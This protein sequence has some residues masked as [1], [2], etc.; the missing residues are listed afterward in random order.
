MDDEVD[1]Y[2]I[3]W[4]YFAKL[5]EYELDKIKEHSPELADEIYNFQLRINPI[6]KEYHSTSITLCGKRF[7]MGDRIQRVLDH[8]VTSAKAKWDF[9]MVVSG[10][11]GAA[12]STIARVLGYYLTKTFSHKNKFSN[13]N[14]V[15]S[16]A[17][18][19][20]AVDELPIGST[21][22]WD[23]FVLAGM[24]TDMGGVQNAII[25]KF[26][27]IR[28]KQLFI[29]LVIPYIWM[30]RT[31]FAIA[32]TK[33][34]LDVYTPDFIKRG[35]YRIWG[36]NK[37]KKLY[38]KGSMA[39]SKWE[40]A[41]RSSF[42]G[43]FLKDIAQPNFF[44]DDEEYEKKKDEAIK[45]IS[46]TGKEK[47]EEDIDKLGGTRSLKVCSACHTQSIRFY[48]KE[49]M[50]KCIACGHEEPIQ[51]DTKISGG[52]KGKYGKVTPV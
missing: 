51:G 43:T 2:N 35:Y 47:K 37:K 24:S 14:I 46:T 28:K 31:Y 22:I 13:D 10:I 29:I 19:Y 12:K 33:L 30:L 26:T 5:T 39:G 41:V 45:S 36:F 48:S 44:T 6:K 40:Y 34:L 21:I 16:H 20:K 15:F 9:V 50:L 52:I 4:D 25:K 11:E 17:Q 42:N 32:R 1:Y 7:Y 18:F 27:L 38:F 8:F 23:E 49:R 3:L